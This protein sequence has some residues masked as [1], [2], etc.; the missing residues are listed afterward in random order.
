MAQRIPTLDEYIF[1]Q[2]MFE[3]GGQEAGKLELVHTT[4]KSALAYANS[5]G[6]DPYKEIPDFDKNYK[7]AQDLAKLGFTQRKDMPVITDADVKMLQYRLSKGFVD[8]HA[9]FRGNNASAEDAFPEGLQGKMADEWLKNGLNDGS[10][11]DDKIKVQMKKVKVGDL[12]PI[13][14]QIYFDKSIEGIAKFGADKS[15]EFYK[16]TFFITSSDNY[17]IDGHHRFLGACIIDPNM[18]V[19]AL[20]IDLPIE[21]LLPMTKAYGDAIG[22][23]R[24][25]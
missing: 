19:G 2:Q 20:Q 21:K 12:K 11:S 6:W 23:A 25:L 4:L 14:Q 16:K 15:A 24:N 18:I 13:Q 3:A 10:A 1:E 22:N 8:V 5:I 9:P 7:Y 17:I